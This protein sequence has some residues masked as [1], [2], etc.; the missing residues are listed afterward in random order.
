[1][2]ISVD[3]KVFPLRQSF[4]ISRGTRTEARVL[5]VTVAHQGAKGRGECVP[6]RRYGETIDNV[7]DAI[8]SVPLPIDRRQL[9]SAMPAGAARNAVDCAL[10]DLESKL[11]GKRVWELAGLDEPEPVS[12]AYTV[13]LDSSELMKAD[14]AAHADW[15]VLKVKLGTG[16]EDRERLR[17]VR[18]GAP[19]SRIIV[20]ANE[21]W[22]KAEFDD[23]ASM[24]PALNIEMVEQPF[25]VDQDDWLDS[26]S[27]EIDICADESFHDRSSLDRLRAGYTTVNVK[28]DKAG[29]LT[30]A[31]ELRREAKRRG[32]RIMV[33]CMIGSSLAMAPAV[34]VAQGADVVDLDGPLFLADDHLPALRYRD[35]VVY[36]PVPEL[37]G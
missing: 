21:G 28:L 25:P 7:A 23:I 27:A 22:S 2:Q 11:T 35:H 20:D 14:A 6:Y 37:W 12:T 1:M 36:P 34:I 17:S 16:K 32:Y 3:E 5:V 24:L 31:L 13:S 10:W 4:T 9:Q 29:G 8:R 26:P 30:E 18:E 19:D 15:P 33:G